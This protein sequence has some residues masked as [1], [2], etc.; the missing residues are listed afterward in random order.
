MLY[1]PFP[2]TWDRA[3]GPRLEGSYGLKYVPAGKDQYGFTGIPDGGFKTLCVPVPVARLADLHECFAQLSRD[4]ELAVPM[5]GRVELRISAVNH[6]TGRGPAWAENPEW[7]FAESFE[8]NGL[9]PLE[10]PQL[11]TANNGTSAWTVRRLVY[12]AFVQVPFAGVE[13]V[14]ER[15]AAR[16]LIRRRTDAADPG[17]GIEFDAFVGPSAIDLQ[18]RSVAWMDEQRACRVFYLLN[19]DEELAKGGVER[20]ATAEAQTDEEARELIR[21]AVLVSVRQRNRLA[22]CQPLRGAR[23]PSVGAS[24]LGHAVNPPGGSLS[25]SCLQTVLE[26]SSDTHTSRRRIDAMVSWS[27]CS[28]RRPRTAICVTTNRNRAGRRVHPNV[29]SHRWARA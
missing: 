11:E 2:E 16:G 4:P 15:L 20:M 12:L 19:S 24:P 14:V 10:Q 23:R 18:G 21:Q 28:I 9:L 22:G 8:A 27:D 13:F 3:M 29:D 6:V 17:P 7:L 1:L 5:G 26:G 25:A